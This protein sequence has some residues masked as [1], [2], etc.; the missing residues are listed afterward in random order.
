MITQEAIKSL[1]RTFQFMKYP[2]KIE[3]E[4]MELTEFMRLGIY[5]LEIEL[6]GF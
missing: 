5:D 4:T 3:F 6:I 2:N 1:E